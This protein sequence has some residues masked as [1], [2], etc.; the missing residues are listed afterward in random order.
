MIPV[1]VH[2]SVPHGTC[3]FI[4]AGRP[5]IPMPALWGV[6]ELHLLVFPVAKLW[7][8]VVF[9]CCCMLMHAVVSHK[10]W[11]GY[12]EIKDNIKRKDHNQAGNSVL[13]HFYVVNSF[14]MVKTAIEMV[15]RKTNFWTFEYSRKPLFWGMTRSSFPVIIRYVL[16][17]KVWKKSCCIT[18]CRLSQMIV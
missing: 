16:T 10:F 1:A 17:T 9:F 6:S 18:Q 2:V 8:F 4:T 14:K 12:K 13:L 3:S 15:R 11:E 7:G 5:K